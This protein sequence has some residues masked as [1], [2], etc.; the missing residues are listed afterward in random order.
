MRNSSRTIRRPPSG[1][2]DAAINAKTCATG[3]RIGA[4]RATMA[5]GAI[6]S[7]TAAIAERII[8][9]GAKTVVTAAKIA[10]IVDANVVCE[11]SSWQT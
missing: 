5:D 7:K 1:S 8:V 4:M 2:K 6:A 10:A 11:S 9:I 3:V